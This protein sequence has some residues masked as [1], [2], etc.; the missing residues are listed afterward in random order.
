MKEKKIAILLMSLLVC[1]W[2]MDYVFAKNVLSVMEPMNLLFLKYAVG[3]CFMLVMKL[4]LDRKSKAGGK[5]ILFFLLCSITGVILYFFCDYT[6]IQYIPI[7]L[8]TVIL[9]FVPVVSII[10]ERIVFKR[11][12]TVKLALGVC[13]SFVG[14]AIVIGADFGAL[15]Q[16]RAIGYLFA[17]GAV[18]SWNAYNFIGAALSKKH[19]SITMG[20]N[21]LLYTLLLLLPHYIYT[22]PPAEAFTP[23]MVGSLLYLGLGS[24]GIG[25]LIL[26][27]GLR[28]LGP[29]VTG[30]FSNFLPITSTI[31]GWIFLGQMITPLQMLGGAIVIAAACLVMVE[32]GKQEEQGV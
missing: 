15:F 8:A 7:S 2:G 12:L 14:V 23:G 29:T 21:Q 1:L 10:I 32:K 9:A 19:T 5:D 27:R 4:A 25:Y 28:M 24:A 31:F 11:R 20:F 22:H 6:A 17:F 30:L 16:G 18:L 26:P 13:F 3:L